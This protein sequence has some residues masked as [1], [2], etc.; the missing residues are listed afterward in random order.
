MNTTN[1]I[2]ELEQLADG[3]D[4]GAAYEV[5]KMYLAGANGV[6]ANYT[7]A[8]WYLE[9]AAANG[10][11]GANYYLG[12][13]YYNGMGVATDYG[14]AKQYFEKSASA[15]NVFS[16]Y[17]LGKIYYWGDGVEKDIAKAGAY[18]TTVL[19]RPLYINQDTDLENFYSIADFEG[20]TKK[21]V[22]EIQESVYDEYK[23]LFGEEN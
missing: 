15:N 8:K 22:A 12:K 17:Y 11:V 10:I 21:Y 2:T 16:N 13:I 9:A 19:N 14:K 20:V 3:G 6:T 7:K 5:G 1:N 18:K 4:F 23:K